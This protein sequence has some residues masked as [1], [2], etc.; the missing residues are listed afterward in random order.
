MQK[1]GSANRAVEL[2]QSAQRKN[3]YSLKDF[4]NIKQTSIC[5][6]GERKGQKTYLKKEWLKTFLTWGRE[7]TSRSGSERVP[8]KMN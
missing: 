5:S 1:K 2:S 4:G 7:Q 8:N 6:T 3:E